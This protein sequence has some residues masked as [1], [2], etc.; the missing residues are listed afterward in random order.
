MACNGFYAATNMQ[1]TLQPLTRSN[2]EGN[3]KKIL[4]NLF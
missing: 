1:V 2:L 4:L 3:D